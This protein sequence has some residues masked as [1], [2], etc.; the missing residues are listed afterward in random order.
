MINFTIS[1][2]EP[3]PMEAQDQSVKCDDCSIVTNGNYY[4]KLKIDLLFRGAVLCQVQIEFKE[5]LIIVHVFSGT[6]FG[7][8]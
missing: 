4:K 1:C 3:E 2:F 8:G 5:R 7:P 6:T